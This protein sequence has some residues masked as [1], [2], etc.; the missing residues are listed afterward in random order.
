MHEWYATEGGQL[1]RGQAE[2]LDVEADL[3]FTSPPWRPGE[4]LWY[5]AVF[6]HLGACLTAHG[7]L[8]VVLGNEWDPPN[9]TT[10]TLSA[11]KLIAMTTGLPIAQMFV[12]VQDQPLMS[13]SVADDMEGQPRVP[14]MH[15]YAWWLSRDPKINRR[16]ATSVVEAGTGP[17]DWRYADYCVEHR[18]EAHPAAM[19]L[20]L[21]EFFVRLLT[22]PHDL[23]VDPF[24]GSN[25]TGAAAERL[26][27]RWLSVEPD[28]RYVDGSRGR[29]EKARD[30]V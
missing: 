29:F 11:L 10:R 18:L 27:R 1:L 2:E 3:I 8:V 30:H 20:S 15:S 19:P 14:D 13:A 4:R 24:A 23:V 5:A 22:D 28:P 12:C 17:E 25:S 16:G 26:G 7:S 9:Q 21:P 6:S